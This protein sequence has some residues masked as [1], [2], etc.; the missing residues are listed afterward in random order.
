MANNEG[1][2]TKKCAGYFVYIEKKRI[3]WKSKTERGKNNKR[4]NWKHVSL[5]IEE[6]TLLTLIYTQN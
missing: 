6:Y 1:R 4:G 3:S 2:P 5:E